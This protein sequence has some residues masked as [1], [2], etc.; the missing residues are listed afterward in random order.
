MNPARRK[1]LGVAVAASAAGVAALALVPRVAVNDIAPSLSLESAFPARFEDWT[2]DPDVMPLALGAELQKVVAESYDQT[3]ARTY[4][5]RRGYRV[6]LSVAYG[7][8]RN[9]GMDIHRP[10]ICYPAQGLALRRDTRETQL[11]VG[12]RRLPVKRLVAGNGERNEPISYWLVIGRGV[13]SFG[14]GH[15]WALLKYGLTGRVP[16]G[17]LVRVSSLDDDDANAFAMHDIFLRDLLSAT[18]PDFRSRLLGDA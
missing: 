15:R 13:A 4:V 10:E 12:G 1:A 3:L 7:G 14:Y 6:M 9:Q 18:T 17:M 5:N 11:V 2:T 8:R 16:D